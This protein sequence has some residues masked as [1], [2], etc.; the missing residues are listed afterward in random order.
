MLGFKNI[1]YIVFLSFV[2]LGCDSDSPSNPLDQKPIL[3]IN[4]GFQKSDD[5]NVTEARNAI[6]KMIGVGYIKFYDSKDKRNIFVV[7]GGTVQGFQLFDYDITKKEPELKNTILEWADY[8]VDVLP[9]SK[10]KLIYQTY[11]P[12]KTTYIHVYDYILEKKISTYAIEYINSNELTLS[13]DEMSFMIE[14]LKIDI[15]DIYAEI[16]FSKR[17]IN[18]DDT[19][20]VVIDSINNLV[21]QDEDTQNNIYSLEE[22]IDVCQKKS[23]YNKYNW[24]LPTFEDMHMLMTQ[25]PKPFRHPKFVYPTTGN[26]LLQTNVSFDDGI[27]YYTIDNSNSE[28]SRY[29]SFQFMRTS[30]WQ[31]YVR[32]VADN[33]IEPLR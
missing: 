23:K 8:I 7:S 21:W 1:I 22:A 28:Y 24:R 9:L 4:D 14:N 5:I 17:N 15:S 25:Q 20:K 11:P 19:K 2:F 18:R 32:C 16:A 27:G 26:S 31:G 12:V 29:L 3:H 33:N 30:N 6:K 10:G 13:L